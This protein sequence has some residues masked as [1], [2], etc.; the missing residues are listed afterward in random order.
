MAMHVSKIFGHWA[1]GLLGAVNLVIGLPTLFDALPFWAYWLSAIPSELALILVGVGLGL[2][3]AWASARVAMQL[4]R[5]GSAV[6][7]ALAEFKRTMRPANEQSRDETNSE[8]DAP[9]DE[10]WEV[11]DHTLRRVGVV[12]G[13]GL[14]VL[15]GMARAKELRGNRYLFMCRF[16][17]A[18]SQH[19]E[20]RIETTGEEVRRRF[21]IVKV[22]GEVLSDMIFHP[23]NTPV[24]S[25]TRVDEGIRAGAVHLL[26]DGDSVL[27]VSV[28]DEVRVKGAVRQR[29]HD[30]LRVPLRGFREAE[31]A[32]KRAGTAVWQHSTPAWSPPEFNRHLSAIDID[33]GMSH[34][35]DP[36]SYEAW[37]SEMASHFGR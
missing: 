35:T 1:F 16:F 6:P 18:G 2:L 17:H 4:A 22:D 3:V 37:K 29:E 19:V 8:Q 33:I 14:P 30:V 27:T 15:V 26:D 5:L 28:T 11:M 25:D 7:A 20:L 12:A 34:V 36:V 24:V 10:K 23:C 9:Q 21:A 32:L 31:A 13:E